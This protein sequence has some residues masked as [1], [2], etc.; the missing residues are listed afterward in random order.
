MP[1]ECVDALLRDGKARAGGIKFIL[2]G[3]AHFAD[4]HKKPAAHSN[5]R[6]CWLGA[7]SLQANKFFFTKTRFERGSHRQ[8]QLKYQ[9]V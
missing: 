3:D 7:G 2:L 6:L 5:L 1:F 9:V 4:D 8:R